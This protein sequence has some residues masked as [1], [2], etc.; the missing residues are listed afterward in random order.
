MRYINDTPETLELRWM[1]DRAGF[2]HPANVLVT[3]KPGQWYEAINGDHG[4]AI[5]ISVQMPAASPPRSEPPS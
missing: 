2:D 4:A 5:R 1:P 3:L